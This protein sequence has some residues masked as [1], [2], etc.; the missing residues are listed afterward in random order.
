MFKEGGNLEVGGGRELVG[1]FVVCFLC[2]L[3]GG[4]SFRVRSE[5]G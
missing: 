2:L 5:D 3:F 4:L 1:I